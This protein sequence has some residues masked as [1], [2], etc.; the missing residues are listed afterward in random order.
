MTA[1]TQIQAEA[2]EE[3]VEIDSIDEFYAAITKWHTHKVGILQHILTVPEG[4]KM[5]IGGGPELLLTGDILDGVK[6]GIALALLE[7]GELPFAQEPQ[8]AEPVAA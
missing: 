2:P 1:D 6:A 7:L 8:V 4:T 3:I 5:A